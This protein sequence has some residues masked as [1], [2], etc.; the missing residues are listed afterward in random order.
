MHRFFPDST[1]L[2]YIT[3]LSLL[4]SVN[5]YNEIQLYEYAFQNID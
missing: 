4:M 5:D 1:T 2:M 3:I